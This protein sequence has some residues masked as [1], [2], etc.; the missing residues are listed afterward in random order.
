MVSDV[1]HSSNLE[2][3]QAQAQALRHLESL[4][5]WAPFGFVF[6]DRDLR[7]VRINEQLAELDFARRA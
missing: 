3:E 6:L 2:D 4:L 7:F 5:T 1:T